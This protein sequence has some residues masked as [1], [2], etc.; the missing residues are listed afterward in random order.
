ML[1]IFLG[2]SLPSDNVLQREN[3]YLCLISTIIISDLFKIDIT[4]SFY[5]HERMLPNN[6]LQV[7]F[8]KE[9]RTNFTGYNGRIFGPV[10]NLIAMPTGI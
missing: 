8:E 3:D 7:D 4:I 10:T 6:K 5:V 9:L 2:L 1:F